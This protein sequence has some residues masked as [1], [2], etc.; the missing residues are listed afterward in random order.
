[1]A[2]IDSARNAK[3]S[4]RNDDVESPPQYSERDNVRLS[5][6]GLPNYTQAISNDPPPPSYDSLYRRVKAAKGESTGLLHFLKSFLIIILSSVLVTIL[7]GIFMSV[8]ISMIVMGAYFKD[9]C[10]A[11]KMIPIYLIVAGCFGCAKNIVS[12]IQRAR[13]TEAEREEDQNN[14]NPIETLVSCFLFAWF[15][16]GC[17]YIYRIKDKVQFEHPNDEYYCDERLYLFAFWITTAV[18]IIIGT[19][20]FCVCCVGCWASLCGD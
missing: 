17:V 20:C 7:I 9:D 12:L 18:Y 16:T 11:E 19:S 10:P 4:S 6:D 2:S 13:K 3:E 8:P 15:I 5:G 1:M 14:V